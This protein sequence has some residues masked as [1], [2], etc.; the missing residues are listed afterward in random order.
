MEKANLIIASM[1]LVFLLFTIQ[2]LFIINNFLMNSFIKQEEVIKNYRSIND[3][4]IFLNSIE[5]INYWAND[6]S[7]LLC[8]N[9]SFMVNFYKIEVNGIN[10]SF[11]ILKT[12]SEKE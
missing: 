9:Q 1:S 6:K 2:L 7:F 5:T 3:F 8:H 10:F 11:P 4:K 12:I